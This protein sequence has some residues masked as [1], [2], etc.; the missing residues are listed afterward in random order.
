[1]ETIGNM[2]IAFEIRSF[3]PNEPK[4]AV[5]S[6]SIVGY[7]EKANMCIQTS[8]EDLREFFSKYG[9]VRDA[10]II[11]DRAEVSKG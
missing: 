7:F 6:G 5:Q 10:R 11:R 8:E 1:M 2:Y 9:S 3:L 4:V